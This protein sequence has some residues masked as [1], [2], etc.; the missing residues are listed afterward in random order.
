MRVVECKQLLVEVGKLEDLRGG[1]QCIDIG[2]SS[3]P[4][5]PPFLPPPSSLPLPPSL[6]ILLLSGMVS[7]HLPD[8]DRDGQGHNTS[9]LQHA[10]RQHGL[11]RPPGR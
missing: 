4:L 10:P 3:L 11:T 5:P 6:P 1:G 7:P 8:G 2:P 9:P